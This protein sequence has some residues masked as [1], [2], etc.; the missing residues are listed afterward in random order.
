M[1]L[2]QQ[3]PAGHSSKVTEIWISIWK[4]IFATGGTEQ[5][6]SGK[7]LSLFLAIYL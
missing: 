2:S 7:L 3:G 4:V 1:T 5:S 6:Y